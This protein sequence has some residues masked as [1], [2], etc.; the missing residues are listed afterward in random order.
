MPRSIGD[1][2]QH[3]HIGPIEQVARFV[4]TTRNP[5]TVLLRTLQLLGET[6]GARGGAVVLNQEAPPR[7]S[8]VARRNACCTISAVVVTP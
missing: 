4:S 5:S 1:I 6:V 7:L 2:A 8:V 3:S